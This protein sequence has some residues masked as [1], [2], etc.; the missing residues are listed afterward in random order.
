[1]ILRCSDL[2]LVSKT[3][4]CFVILEQTWLFE[5]TQ[6]I[7]DKGHCVAIAC[8]VK[9]IKAEFRTDLGSIIFRKH[10]CFALKKSLF[11]RSLNNNVNMLP[12][13]ALKYV[14]VDI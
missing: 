11:G 13:S 12:T 8:A 2:N 1:M 4:K 7:T 9:K 5:N 6:V 10:F 14:A 3:L